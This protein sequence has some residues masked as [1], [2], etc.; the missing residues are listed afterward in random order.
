[1]SRAATR[2]P[3]AGGGRSAGRSRDGLPR[4][5]GRRAVLGA[6]MLRA[7]AG[8]T[9]AAL[10]GALAL[11]P[12]GRR[13]LAIVALV[14]TVLSAAYMLWLRDSGLV[15]VEEVAITGPSGSDADRLRA[16]LDGAAREM[17]TL[18]VDRDRL[19]AIAASFPT[20][21]A[22][23]IERDLPSGLRIRVIEHRPVAMLVDGE[24]RVPVAADG[25]ILSGLPAGGRLPELTVREGAGEKRLEPGHGLAAAELAGGAPAA[26]RPR[27]ASVTRGPERGFVITLRGEGPELI[28]GDPTRIGAKWA[29]ANRVLADGAA[30]AAY[31][32]VR[33]PDRPV[34]GGASE[35][36][37]VPVSPAPEAVPP[38]VP[39]EPEP[40][41][42]V[43]PL[44]P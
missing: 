44:V 3:D 14:A 18:H 34:T 35:D 33:L 5:A 6:R 17:T 43:E 21:R 4:R 11:G 7:A 19:E 15:A 16:A 22:L 28:F 10:R 13:R 31:L 29:A 40:V 37:A 2:R 32:D 1:M 20:V 27:L 36:P 30:D 41:L 9:P 42:P 26:L 24:R 25:S 38:V 8:R 23:A 12:R 39:V